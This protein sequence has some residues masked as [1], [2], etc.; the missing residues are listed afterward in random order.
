VVAEGA[1]QDFQSFLAR[2]RAEHA[3]DVLI[4]DAPVSADQEVTAVVDTLSRQGRQPLVVFNDVT[5]LGAKVVTNMFA[6]R[7]RVAR[8]FGVSVTQLH[9]AYQA[10]A[11]Q[12][13]S[14]Q[15]VASGPVCDEAVWAT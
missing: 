10:R 13:V 11:R 4:I 12:L 15:D 5:G 8:L 3:D 2:Y 9:E 6:S 14:P 1:E 7:E